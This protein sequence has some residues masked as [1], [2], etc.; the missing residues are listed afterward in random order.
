VKYIL[1]FF[2]IVFILPLILLTF[3]ILT[4]ARTKE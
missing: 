1:S 3:L 2:D 4:P